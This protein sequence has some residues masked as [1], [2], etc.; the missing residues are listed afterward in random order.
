[1]GFRPIPCCSDGAARHRYAETGYDIDDLAGN[2]GLPSGQI[3]L[4]YIKNLFA[5]GACQP[6]LTGMLL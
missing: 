3:I 4:F 5:D 6:V 1:M 2:L